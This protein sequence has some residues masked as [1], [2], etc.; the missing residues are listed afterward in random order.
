MKKQVFL[1]LALAL[2]VALAPSLEAQMEISW[3]GRKLVGYESWGMPIFVTKAK[4]GGLSTNGMADRNVVEILD[5]NDKR[6]GEKT[7]V[8]KIG[9]DKRYNRYK[10]TLPKDYFLELSGSTKFSGPFTAPAFYLIRGP[11]EF[12]F[13]TTI[14]RN[15]T[16][17][18][19]DITLPKDDM[20]IYY[21][22]FDSYY[23]ST[24]EQFVDTYI[25]PV[26]K[27]REVVKL[28]N[29]TKDRFTGY[30]TGSKNN[31]VCPEYLT[32]G[33]PCKG[34]IPPHMTHT[35]AL[36]K[37][38]FAGLL[39]LIPIPGASALFNALTGAEKRKIK[40]T[41]YL[42][43]AIGYHYGWYPDERT[44]NSRFR[45]DAIVLLSGTDP[46]PSGAEQIGTAA[47]EEMMTRYG[48]YLAKTLL[49]NLTSLVSNIP[50]VGDVVT[51]AIALITTYWD[52]SEIGENAVSYFYV[53]GS[54]PLRWNLVYGVNPDTN[55]IRNDLPGRFFGTGSISGV[56]YGNNTW[57]AVG[58]DDKIAYSTDNGVNWTGV[59][60]G[61]GAGK[62]GY[63]THA[64]SAAAFGNNRFV[65][66]GERGQI[67]Y[68]ADN[69]KSWTAVPA[70]NK[71][72]FGNNWV[73]GIAFGGGRFVAVGNNGK[74]AYSTDGE[75]WV[76][77]AAANNGGFGSSNIRGIAFGNN[78]FIAVGAGGKMAYSTNGERWTAITTKNSILPMSN[79][80]FGL[81][82]NHINAVAYGDYGDS[83]WVA[84]GQGGKMA[85]SVDGISWKAV[86]A[87]N[88]GGFGNT[89]INGVAWGYGAWVAVGG[90]GKMAF[91][92]DGGKTWRAVPII[93][94]YT[95]G[96]NNIFGITYANGR[97]ITVGMNARIAYHE[98]RSPTDRV[99]TPASTPPTPA[100]ATGPANW[101]AVSDSTFGTGYYSGINGVAFG[102][103]TWVAVGE[104]N[105]K[106]AY[107]SDGRS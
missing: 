56:A 100:P 2:A 11:T 52:Y 69:G 55:N 85:Y 8:D 20:T 73:L 82:N 103:N 37:G 28:Y 48:G 67:V 3:G 44:F 92:T 46:P 90:A 6:V 5:Q 13:F 1:F 61:P 79:S 17:L 96:S 58:S 41:A 42:A 12:T 72:G 59:T 62:S 43:A 104:R 47:M 25:M 4:F 75:R 80:V 27:Y 89:P 97:F 36:G 45:E 9:V 14:E 105:G 39:E 83:K 91:S 15:S 18:T 78:R 77:V 76:P 54:P 53:R 101:T 74:I 50:V 23:R 19:V 38:F 57:V 106:I 107:S 35:L 88:N 65:A 93:A 64:Y 33:C 24:A 22:D 66:V 40:E 94:F 95:T 99:V 32:I 102:N 30:V 29:E 98:M 34:D 16:L 51:F 71:G 86:E 26:M 49:P 70:G 87:A 63:F 10:I 84:V 81:V 7:T 31:D 21:F 60:D 68:S